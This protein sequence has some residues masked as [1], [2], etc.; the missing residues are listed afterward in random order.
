L[1]ESLEVELLIE[2]CKFFV[3]G[4]GEQLVGKVHEHAIVAGSVV[5]EGALELGGHEVRVTGGL[6]Q[7]VEAGEQLVARGILEHE[8]ATDA[9]AE[10]EQLGCP[11]ALDQ[12]GVAGK[13]NAQ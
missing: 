9:A 1:G 12:T 8:T 4:N 11:Q 7:M 10:W 5:A 3:S 2:A 13:H 6:E